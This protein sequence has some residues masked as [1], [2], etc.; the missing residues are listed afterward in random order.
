MEKT[1]SLAQAAKAREGV[2]SFEKK[3]GGVFA[4]VFSDHFQIR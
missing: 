3:D 1:N 4:P 2:G